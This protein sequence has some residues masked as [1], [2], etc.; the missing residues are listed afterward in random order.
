[1]GLV[2]PDTLEEAYQQHEMVLQLAPHLLTIS[3]LDCEALDVMY[4]FDFTFEGNHDE[5]VAEALGVI[6]GLEAMFEGGSARVINYEPTITLAL[7]DSCRLQA[8]LSIETRTNAYQVRTGEFGD[9]QISLYFT[10]RQYWGQGTEGTFLDAFRRQRS[11]G[12]ELLQT[13][14]IPR[15]VRPLARAIASR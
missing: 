7:E 3:V 1:S 4:G 10:V 6:P 9:D 8:R 5:V 13:A 2:N 11:L 14:V 15:I 12:E